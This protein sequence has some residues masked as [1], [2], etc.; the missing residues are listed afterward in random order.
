MPTRG[1]DGVGNG[2]TDRTINTTK[3][4]GKK[5]NFILGVH[6]PTP[7][8]PFQIDKFVNNKNENTAESKFH[9]SEKKFLFFEFLVFRKHRRA[10]HFFTMFAFLY[11]T[12]YRKSPDAEQLIY[13]EKQ[14]TSERT[15]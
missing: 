2:D 8:L 10:R 11:E 9:Y 15:K 6:A 5:N 3:L 4:H 13:R 14:T 1:I 12:R 7:T